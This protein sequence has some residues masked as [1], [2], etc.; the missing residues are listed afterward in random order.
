MRFEFMAEQ[1]NSSLA[2]HR[3][4]T[5]DVELLRLPHREA[6]LIVRDK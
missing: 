1:L 6:Y 5:I 4:T 3:T 2:P